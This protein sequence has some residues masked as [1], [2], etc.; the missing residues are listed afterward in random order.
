[1][2][3]TTQNA[4]HILELISEGMTVYDSHNEPV[5]TVSY[6]QFTDE[7][8]TQPGPETA[9]APDSDHNTTFVEEIANALT[10]GAKLPEEMRQR[11]MREG[12]V[13]IDTGILRSE[14]YFL[15]HQISR[16]TD[17]EVHLNIGGDELIH[18]M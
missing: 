15:P 6:V 3:D 5:G 13:C 10:A 18:S 8:P 4:N 9:S 7:D 2:N 12:F 11:M 17:K 16:V 14:K 1:M